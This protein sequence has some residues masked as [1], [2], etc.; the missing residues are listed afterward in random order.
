LGLNRN[1]VAYIPR[2]R[3]DQELHENIAAIAKKH[4]RYGLPRV[5]RELRKRGF[6]D[7]HKRIG[8]VYRSMS[9]QV[10]KRMRR[11]LVVD[12]VGPMA[13]PVKADERWSLD[14]VS[15]SLQWGRKFRTL[16]IIDDCTRES[17]QIDVAFGIT[18][19]RMTRVLDDIARER[20]YPQTVV[21]DNGPEMRSS[22]MQKWAAKH[23]VKLAF[24]EPG[25]PIQNAFVESF[26]GRFR[27]ECL[28]E[29]R[30]RS[31]H[32]A[33]EIIAAWREHYNTHRPH[34]ALGGLSPMK[35]ATT[36]T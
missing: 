2:G 28:N 33:Q 21:L 17:L 25:K 8:R 15:D 18:G 23:G 9:L 11:K 31:L 22:A 32:H 36:L 13:R 34:S 10:R 14:F 7:N 35:Y 16:N 5:I 26:N 24:I 3:S 12:R 6:C 29:H 4:H 19:E 20:K 27:D 1:I 30:F